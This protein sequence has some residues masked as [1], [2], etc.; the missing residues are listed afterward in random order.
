MRSSDD[1]A[2]E[3]A[4]FYTVRD[5]CRSKRK[6]IP[7]TQ[8]LRAIGRVAARLG[9]GELAKNSQLPTITVAPIITAWRGS[10]T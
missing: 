6:T 8:A 7:I 10:A 9:D 4:R 3:S 5:D 1:V 2:D